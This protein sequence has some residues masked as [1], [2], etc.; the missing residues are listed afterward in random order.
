MKMKIF[1][2]L[3]L[4]CLF[5]VS[6]VWSA[7]PA[8][9]QTANFLANVQSF[10]LQSNAV[11]SATLQG[12]SWSSTPSTFYVNPPAVVN[13]ANCPQITNGILVF[14]NQMTGVPYQ[15]TLSGYAQWTTN[16]LVPTNATPDANGNVNI[17]QYAGLYISQG[18]FYYSSPIVSNVNVTASGGI[19]LTNASGPMSV[20]NGG[21]LGTNLSL[22]QLPPGVVTNGGLATL[23]LLP[24]GTPQPLAWWSADSLAGYTNGQPVASVPDLSGNGWALTGGGWSSPNGTYFQS[25]AINGRPAIYCNENNTHELTNHGFGSTLNGCSNL[26]MFIV[27]RDMAQFGAGYYGATMMDDDLSGIRV[28]PY[29]AY[30][31]GS[32]GV[33]N[34][35]GADTF[36]INQ[37]AITIY[38]ITQGHNLPKVQCFTFSAA[39]R[40]CAIYN[41]GK[42]SVNA[43]T[44][45]GNAPVPVTGTN[46]YFGAQKGGANFQGYISECIIFTNGL[47][48]AQMDTMNDWLTWK[49]SRQAKNLWIDGDSR[50]FGLCSTVGSNLI[51]QVAGL[52]PGWDMAGSPQGGKTIAYEYSQMSNWVTQ[53][54]HKAPA[55]IVTMFGSPNDFSGMTAPQALTQLPLTEASFTNY[56]LVCHSNNWQFII[57]TEVSDWVETNGYRTNL[58]GWIASN[59]MA[60]ADG[61]V[62]YSGLI[63]TLG[64]NGAYANTNLFPDNLHPST[65]AYSLMAPVLAQ[66]IQNL[67]NG[68]NLQGTFTGNAANLTNLPAAQLTGTVPIASLTP[69]V[70]TNMAS[71]F[72]YPP[73]AVQVLGAGTNGYLQTSSGSWLLGHSGASDI[74]ASGGVL[75][76]N[77]QIGS[78]LILGPGNQFYGNLAGGTNLPL[79]G[80]NTNGSIS[81]NGTVT[82]TNFTGNGA[83]LTG[84]S[85]ALSSLTAA[86]NLT[87]NATNANVP[88]L[89]SGQNVASNNAVTFNGNIRLNGY[90]GVYSTN[91]G[92]GGG[93][94]TFIPFYFGNGGA[95]G[96][97]V[98]IGSHPFSMLRSDGTQIMVADSTGSSFNSTLQAS[99]FIAS[100]GGTGITTNIALS[101]GPTLYIT[102][103]IIVGAH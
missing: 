46:W 36:L 49:Y 15:L 8:A 45:S 68:P 69:I 92:G 83:G 38:A 23:G 1:R 55:N 59:W 26:A 19:T 48:L 67:I 96:F 64:T 100:S 58:N 4:W 88:A 14:S 78:S 20:V 90:S 75:S 54:R 22:A 77:D 52:L 57:G 3:A 84:V 7:A 89:N 29:D 80:L 60:F 71:L 2:H 103:G 81:I 11:Y 91:T 31:S 98:Q 34:C 25:G 94:S 76:I 33:Y 86:T 95:N 61:I 30:Y 72:G 56:A 39:T 82:A 62:D 101:G 53:V 50:S 99:G 41:D 16:I 37:S 21:G 40:D 87:L 93:A 6:A 70:P 13:S 85:V 97:Q 102:N 44:Q 5:G 43:Q 28:V 17:G 73:T 51:E 65:Y 32:L 9:A 79:A 47:T 18:A 24:V 63:P 12:L 35:S 27:S 66:A 74:S 10:N 42:R